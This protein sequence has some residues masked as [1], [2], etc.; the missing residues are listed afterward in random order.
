MHVSNDVKLNSSNLWCVCVCVGVSRTFLESLLLSSCLASCS[1]AS[2]FSVGGGAAEREFVTVR[3][4]LLH[5]SKLG[6]W[7]QTFLH[8]NETA[9]Q[10]PQTLAQHILRM[11]C[12]YVYI[13][14]TWTYVWGCS[15]APAPLWLVSG[16]A[17]WR[18]KKKRK[19]CFYRRIESVK[20]RCR[21]KHWRCYQSFI[22]A[23]NKIHFMSCCFF[24]CFCLCFLHSCWEQMVIQTSR[25]A[26]TEHGFSQ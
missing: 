3:G 2:F 20:N 14:F 22:L 23:E 15:S 18:G 12:M 17:V 7:F 10:R 4:S 25:A 21:I 24:F 9:L 6:H 19:S 8:V 11:L 26:G 1:S 5:A 13:S 16:S